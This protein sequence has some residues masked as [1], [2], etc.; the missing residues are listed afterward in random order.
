MLSRLV[1]KS[2]LPYSRSF[3][4]HW[5]PIKGSKVIGSAEEVPIDETKHFIKIGSGRHKGREI[6]DGG[7]IWETGRSFHSD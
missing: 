5:P 7:W 3:V 1:S 2:L 6:S 4:A